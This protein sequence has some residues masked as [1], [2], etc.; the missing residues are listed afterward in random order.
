MY[1]Y[2]FK[3]MRLIFSLEITYSFILGKKE[4]VFIALNWGHTIDQLE[5]VL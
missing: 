3:A 4:T 1:K 5:I 2:K